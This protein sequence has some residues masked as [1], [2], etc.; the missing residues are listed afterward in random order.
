M[1]VTWTQQPTMRMSQ[2]TDW[3]MALLACSACVS[4]HTS[5]QAESG[6][7]EL[8]LPLPSTAAAL[9]HHHHCCCCCSTAACPV[10]ACGTAGAA[11]ACMPSLGLCGSHL[12]LEVGDDGTDELHHGHDQRAV[13]RRAEVVVQGGRGSLYEEVGRSR[14]VERGHGQTQSED[15]GDQT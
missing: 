11:T 7:S 12:P 8:L 2:A 5:A 15:R 1:A 3:G 10:P 13:R 9:R 4:Q 6:Q 14:E